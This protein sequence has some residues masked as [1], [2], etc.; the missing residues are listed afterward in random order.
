MH[1][2]IDL[3]FPPTVNSYYNKTRNGIFI[4][5]KG[6]AFRKA[7][8]A[9]CHEQSCFNLNLDMK[10]TLDVILYPPDRRCR[11][12]DNYMKA[13]QDAL[14]NPKD[15]NGAKVW[16]DDSQIDLL[17]IHRGVLVSGGLTRCRIQEHHGFILPNT[18]DVW[19]HI[20]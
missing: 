20:D 14:G 5:K 3:P 19:D 13:L 15:G 6:T 2:Y 1:I 11:D 7:C 8:A 10:L 18:P 4:S 9:A 17:P 16:L 12:L